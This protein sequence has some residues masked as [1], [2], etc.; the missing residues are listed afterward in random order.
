[1]GVDDETPKITP[2]DFVLYQNYPNPFNPNT[3][4]KFVI[5]KSSFVNL[6]IYNVLGKDVATLVNE[7]RP[8]ENHE[9]EFNA[10]DLPSGVYFYRIKAGLFIETKKMIL[11]K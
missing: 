2:S 3:K 6:K 10:T 5:P 4:I 1:V 7:E 9:V 11:M 8:A